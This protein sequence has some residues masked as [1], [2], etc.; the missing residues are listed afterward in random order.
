[1]PLESGRQDTNTISVHGEVT[2]R[3]A[4]KPDAVFWNYFLSTRG[5][6]T[7]MLTFACDTNGHTATCSAT[8]VTHT[9]HAG[10]STIRRHIYPLENQH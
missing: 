4:H 7:R 8:I 9:G 6:Q 2:C 3:P 10:I 1:M 5:Y